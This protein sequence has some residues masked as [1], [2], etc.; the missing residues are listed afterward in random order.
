MSG[1]NSHV[2]T[3]LA[4]RQNTQGS[5]AHGILQSAHVKCNQ[6]ETI[7]VWG[8]VS[9]TLLDS[10]T[11]ALRNAPTH[12]LG[13]QAHLPLNLRLCA[14]VASSRV[15]GLAAQDMGKYSFHQKS[16]MRGYF[17]SHI[18]AQV[19]PLQWPWFFSCGHTHHVV[20]GKWT[21]GQEFQPLATSSM[22]TCSYKVLFLQSEFVL[23]PLLTFVTQDMNDSRGELCVNIQS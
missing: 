8:E 17:F 3:P 16:L 4:S 9:F 12:V 13:H 5:T 11:C 10:N 6:P 1:C 22:W 7:T 19:S 18:Q 15:A 21:K 14:L 20:G 23:P 2:K